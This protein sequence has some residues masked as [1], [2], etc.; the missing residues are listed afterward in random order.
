MY[1]LLILSLAVFG[2][3]LSYRKLSKFQ[4]I[5]EYLKFEFKAHDQNLNLR[6]NG[7]IRQVV[8]DLKPVK[9]WECSFDDPL[10]MFKSIYRK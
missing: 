7:A 10:C 1:R 8:P 2:Q 9:Q 5:N 4:K 6:L 3:Y